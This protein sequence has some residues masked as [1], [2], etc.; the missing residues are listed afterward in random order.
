MSKI[1]PTV[2][3]YHGTPKSALHELPKELLEVSGLSNSA[4]YL[5]RLLVE[6]V[7]FAKRAGYIAERR[8]VSIGFEFPQRLLALAITIG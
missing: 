1:W 2:P 4:N 7:A 3:T 5:S 8:V 6:N